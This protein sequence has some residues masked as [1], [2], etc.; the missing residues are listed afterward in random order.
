MYAKDVLVLGASFG[1]YSKRSVRT[2]RSAN[3]EIAPSFCAADYNSKTGDKKLFFQKV[4]RF[5]QE[6]E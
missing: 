4:N 3:R 5:F 1:A 2:S 6:V